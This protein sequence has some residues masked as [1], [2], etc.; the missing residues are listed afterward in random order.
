MLRTIRALVDHQAD[1][2]PDAPYLIAPETGLVLS[3]GGLRA[4]SLRLAAWL[5]GEGIRPGAKVALLMPNGYQTCRL[6]IGAM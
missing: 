5:Q 2:R 1:L 4:A 6:F 3:F